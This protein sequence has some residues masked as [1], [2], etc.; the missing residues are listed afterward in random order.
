MAIL[1]SD[2]L[3]V[4][5]NSAR[6]YKHF[7]DR[8]VG[9]DLLRRIYDL[10]KMGPTTKN[11]SPMRIVFVTTPEAKERLKPALKDSSREAVMAAPVTAII[12]YDCDF[13]EHFPRLYPE[14]DAY[15]HYAGKPEFIKSTAFRNSSLQGA[16]FIIAARAFG[17]DC[18]PFSSFDNA[19]VDKAFFPDGKIKSNFLCSLG[20]GDT[21]TLHG[22][23]PRLSFE[24]VCS[25]A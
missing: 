8:P 21:S 4:I 2:A 19:V 5:F 16:Y 22:R 17:L 13:Y 12:A 24:E 23:Y 7:L 25:F 14:G 15:G 6:S 1:S 20:Y 9:E 11:S 10:A 3:D 18:G